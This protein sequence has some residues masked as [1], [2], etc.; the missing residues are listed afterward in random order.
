MPV[1]QAEKPEIDDAYADAR[2]ALE[3]LK[4]G[5]A[6][7]EETVE[8]ATDEPV[9]TAQE[10]AERVR[11]ERG[12][13]APKEAKADEPAKVEAK[14]EPEA[15]ERP[16]DPK[17]EAP[18]QQTAQVSAPP[19]GFSVKTKAEWDKLPEYVRADIVK[20]EQEVSDGFKQ[21]SGM[22][23]IMPYVEM[24]QRG[25][26]TLKAALDNYTG[27]ENLLRQDVVK[28]V[29]QIA[30]NMGTHPVELAQRIFQAYGQQPF[31]QVQADPSNP[32]P[33]DP[34]VLQQ[35][36]NPLLQKVST[37][38]HHITQQQQAEQARQQSVIYTAMERFK[39]DPAHRYFEN[40]R[41]LM[42]QLFNGGVVQETGDTLADMKTAYEMACNLDPDIRELSF[43][44]RIAKD[45]ADRKQR[46]KDAA[47]K[48]R[49]ASRSITGSPSAAVRETA[50]TKSG[51]PFDD[52]RRAYQEVGARV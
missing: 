16:A 44:E 31:Q 32:Q 3:E 40:V 33:F 38:E 50:D 19:P 18:V 6:D 15:I 41:P 39:S 48:A 46:E 28:G 51:S 11:D 49:Q 36:L 24:A 10:T 42:A 20:R 13:F 21:Y 2:A 17:L 52:A 29:S 25:G 22:K 45:E 26:T 7:V 30:A 23:E 37:L 14:A 4:N 34:S 43:K 9:E 8:A 1:E 47:D 35:H 5:P 12:R 27:L